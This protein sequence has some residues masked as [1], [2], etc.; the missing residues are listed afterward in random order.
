MKWR[1]ALVNVVI[2]LVVATIC[3]LLKLAPLYSEPQATQDSSDIYKT[4]YNGWKWWHV[5]CYRCH[6]QNAVGGSLAPTLIDPNEKFTLKEF[7]YR[8]KNGSEDGAMQ[9]W[10]KLLD[11]KQ[12]TQLYYYVLARTDKVLPPGRPDEVGP[13]GGHWI[14][15]QGW[16]K[17]K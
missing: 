1:T 2:F 13:K 5:Y 11:D 12:I 3:I 7:L 16:P 4:V 8:V 14:P 6:G 15:P 10:D 17:S 9:P